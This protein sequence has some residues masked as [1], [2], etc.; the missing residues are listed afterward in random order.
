VNLLLD[1]HVA[2]WALADP[3]A[4]LGPETLAA[5]RDRRNAV[6]VSAATVWEVEIKRAIGKL[7]APDGFAAECLDRGFDELPITFDHAAAAARLPLLHSDPFDRMLIGQASVE[8]YR[9][10]TLDRAFADYDVKLVD[11]AN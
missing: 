2:L 11:P 8:G 3:D 10:V 7:D 1:T 4:H 5:L 6:A 9:I